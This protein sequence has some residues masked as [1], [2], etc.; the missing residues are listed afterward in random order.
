MAPAM[1]HVDGVKHEYADVNG[2]RLHYAEAGEGEPVVLQHG[3]PQHWWAWR[4]QIPALAERYRVICPD[5]RGFGW[6]EAPASGYEKQQLADELLALL[7]VLGIERVRYAGHD[8]GAYTG[9]LAGFAHPERFE[10]IAGLAVP[11]PWGARVPPPRVAL[12]FATYQSIVSSPVLGRQAVKRGMPKLLLKAGRKAGEFTDDEVETY[13]QIWRQDENANA[14]VQVYR[15]FL[16]KELRQ[17]GE[18]ARKRLTPRTL[19]MMGGSDLLTKTVDE[20]EY[21]KHADDLRVEILD[22]AAHWLPEEKPAEVTELLLELF[23]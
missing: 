6:S 19:V 20:A 5:F 9:Y 4:H 1:P 15:T 2:V 12:V 10:R 17:R 14:S 23:A 7:D 11:P 22:G 3:W 13:M 18:L 21:Q 8:W 16:R